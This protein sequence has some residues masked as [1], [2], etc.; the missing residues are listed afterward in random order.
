[1]IRYTLDDPELRF[2]PGRQA[3]FLALIRTLRDLS[4]KKHV[5][6]LSFRDKW[7]DLSTES[8]TVFEELVR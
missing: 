5:T 2:N 1:M 3:S 4:G 8:G 6:E 7:L